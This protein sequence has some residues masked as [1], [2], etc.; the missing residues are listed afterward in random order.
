MSRVA[1]PV[2]LVR[3]AVQRFGLHPD[4]PSMQGC[5][6][7]GG[8]A[9]VIATN[10][11]VLEVGKATG[12]FASELTAAYYAFLDAGMNVDVASPKGGV[13]PVDPLS[14]NPVVR[15][16]ADDRF[17]SDE[18]LLAKVENSMNIAE[19]DVEQYDIVY[20]AGGWG[21]AFDLGFSEALAEKITRANAADKVIGGVC[22]GPLGLI[23]ATGTDGRPLVE[24]RHV[25][26]VSD[27]QV[28]ELG[29]AETPQHPETELRRKGADFSSRSR[30]RDVLANHWVVDGNLVTGQNQNAGPMV[31]REML[32]LARQRRHANG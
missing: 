17:L 32:R 24:G 14:V 4:G 5:D 20:L 7:P 23:N 21:A 6:L 25:T 12:V 19:V 29:V 27:R 30:F 15:T 11:G 8:K 18:E 31:A 9:L 16:E 10:R 28:K 26:A 22:H 2:L 1:L 3:K 13:I